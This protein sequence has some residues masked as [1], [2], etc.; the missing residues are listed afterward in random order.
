MRRGWRA[1][2]RG[3]LLRRGPF[4]APPWDFATRGSSRGRLAMATRVTS[5]KGAQAGQPMLR[6]SCD[7]TS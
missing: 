6:N 4:R 1:C 7:A 2:V 5:W 3:G